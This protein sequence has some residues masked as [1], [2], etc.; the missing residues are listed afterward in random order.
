MAPNILIAD[1][2]NFTFAP[3]ETL[4]SSCQS[5]PQKRV[6]RKP[7]RPQRQAVE[8]TTPPQAPCY[9]SDSEMKHSNR[10]VQPMAQNILPPKFISRRDSTPDLNSQQNAR[11]YLYADPNSAQMLMNTQADLHSMSQHNQMTQMS[12][13]KSLSVWNVRSQSAQNL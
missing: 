12:S 9:M 5:I 13:Q 11:N 6:N 8:Q 3:K 10:K 4:S 1:T 2:Q 7:I